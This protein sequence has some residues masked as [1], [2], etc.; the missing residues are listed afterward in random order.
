MTDE[1]KPLDTAPVT[2]PDDLLPLTE[3]L[4]QHT[5]DVSTRQAALETLKLL[6]AHGYRIVAPSEPAP[7][8]AIP[9]AEPAPPPITPPAEPAPPLVTMPDVEAGP[10][11]L[12]ARL[13]QLQSIQGQPHEFRLLLDMWNTRQAE[14]SLWQHSPALYRHLGHRCLMLGAASQAHEVVRAALDHVVQLPD[15]YMHAPWAEDIELRQ[16]YGLALARTA[17]PE[18]AQQVLGALRAAGHTDEETLGMLGRTYKD[19]AIAAATPD[20]RDQFLKRA[21]ETYAEAYRTSG[22][23]WSGINA[24]T[25]NLLVGQTAQANELARKVREQ[26]LKEVEGRTGDSYWEFAALGEAALILHDLSQATEW[27]SRAANEGRNRFGDLQSSR[28]NARLVLQHWNEDPNWIDSYL[29]IPAVIVFAGHMIDRPGRATPRFPIELEPLVAKEIRQKLDE[30]EPR[31]GFSSAA[32]GSDILFL[33]AMLERGAEVSIVLP[34]NEEEF[35]RDSVEIG[36]DSKKWR[37]RFDTVLAHAARVIT[38]S[39]QRLEIGG[40][41]YEFCNQLLL[42]LAT[43]RCRQL[44]SRLIPLAV[45]NQQ[46]GDGPG[47]AASVVQS[48]R[49]LGRNPEI[50]DLAKICRG[51]GSLPEGRQRRPLQ[52]EFIASKESHPTNGFASRIVA[53]LF[54]DAV[55][56]SKLSEPEVPRFVQHFFGGIADL[57]EN[58]CKTI[59]ANNT[60]GDGLYFVFSEINAAGEFALRLA[61][62]AAKTDWPGKGLRAELNLRVALHAGPVYEFDDP[63]TRRRNYSGTHVS[64][65]ARIEPI[66][67]PGQVYASEAFAALAAACGAKKFTCDYVGQTPMAKGYG[68]LPTYHVRLLDSRTS[69]LRSS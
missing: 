57:M 42:G 17:N 66:T 23:Y 64:R 63:I 6:A 14:P 31:F 13:A 19:L 7:P 21:A 28:R 45:W 65:A 3:F 9:P 26:C 40:I 20:Q 18:Q 67:P 56:F 41:S 58:F 5:D 62:L 15:G 4:A 35:I 61:E 39:N 46:P 27:Y 8:P 34:Y 44:E 1:P 16:I 43:I 52:P 37:A 55:G 69:P 29:R 60:W 47:G 22:G 30:L 48:W 54:A 2:L 32:C 12:D 53:I 36:T 10:H 38:A 50:V 11:D 49:S 68:T 59:I 51:S 33:E 24:A 25:M